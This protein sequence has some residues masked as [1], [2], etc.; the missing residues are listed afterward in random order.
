MA[1]S[2]RYIQITFRRFGNHFPEFS[3][4]LIKKRFWLQVENLIGFKFLLKILR[5]AQPLNQNWSSLSI[6]RQGCPAQRLSLA[7]NV[8][9]GRIRQE[10][11]ASKLNYAQQRST[12]IGLIKWFPF[13]RNLFSEFLDSWFSTTGLVLY[14]DP[15]YSRYVSFYRNSLIE[16]INTS[17]ILINMTVS[18]ILCK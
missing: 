1:K 15:E 12:V 3:K 5:N 11:C 7:G 8:K 13:D 2:Y 16:N 9:S 14:F 17:N 4:S 18:S 10:G 6:S